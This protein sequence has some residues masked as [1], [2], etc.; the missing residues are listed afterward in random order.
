MVTKKK[1]LVYRDRERERVEVAEADTVRD[2]GGCI[3]QGGVI[4]QIGKQMLLL[5]VRGH[6]FKGIR[7]HRGIMGGVYKRQWLGQL[8]REERVIT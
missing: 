3:E 2:W 7:V 1:T 5:G 6:R 4:G 8:Y